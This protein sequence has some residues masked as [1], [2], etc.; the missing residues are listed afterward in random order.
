[1]SKKIVIERRRLLLAVKYVD[2]DRVAPARA[3][4]AALNL[5]HSYDEVHRPLDRA[6]QK[7]RR[8]G[9]IR[10]DKAERSWEL[11]EAGAAELAADTNQPPSPELG[12]TEEM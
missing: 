4:A 3:V 5:A 9:L 11:T 10:F 7:A 2:R 6:L 12:Q 8:R 1:M